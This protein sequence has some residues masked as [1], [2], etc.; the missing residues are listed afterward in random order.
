M[1]FIDLLKEKIPTLTL[2]QNEE[3]LEREIAELVALHLYSRGLISSG[4]AAK[5]I[6]I[7]RNEFILLAGIGKIPMFEYSEEELN[8]EL[9]DI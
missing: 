8:H 5:I 4:N 2:H 9:Q 3:R 7:P 1:K 6:G